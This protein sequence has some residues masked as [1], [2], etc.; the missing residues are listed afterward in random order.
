MGPVGLLSLFRWRGA[1][2]DA[3]GEEGGVAT[4]GFFIFPAH[5]FLFYFLKKI[6]TK[7]VK[8][9]FWGDSSVYFA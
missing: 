2:A 3:H 7:C 1:A 8:I 4:A 6:Y 5:F 9:W